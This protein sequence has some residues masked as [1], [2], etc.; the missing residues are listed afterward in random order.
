MYIQNARLVDAIFDEENKYRA[1]DG[2]L[3]RRIEQTTVTEGDYINFY[4]QRLYVHGIKEVR[5]YDEIIPTE[6]IKLDK[7]LHLFSVVVHRN[8]L[9]V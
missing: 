7:N 8:F 3:Y 5:T 9:L 6:T 4:T 2:K 1:P